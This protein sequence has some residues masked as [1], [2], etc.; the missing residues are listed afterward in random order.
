MAINAEID[1]SS[2]GFQ[3]TGQN[4]E[5]GLLSRTVVAAQEDDLTG[6]N[7]ARDA[8][9]DRVAAEGF[10]QVLKT[11]ERRRSGGF[12]FGDGRLGF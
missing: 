9:E 2:V 8:V 3:A 12:R 6:A 5:K 7:L 1:S 4:I 11:Q 10:G